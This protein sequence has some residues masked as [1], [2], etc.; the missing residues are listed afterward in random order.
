MRFEDFIKE[1]EGLELFSKGWRGL[2]YRGYWKGKK[3]SIKRAK[4]G[5]EQAIRKECE[6]LRLLK[7]L[8]GFPQ[9]VACGEDFL[10]YE[11]IE[12]VPLEKLNLSR[13]ERIRV[14]LK[15]LEYVKLLDSLGINKDELHRLDK[16]TL[17]TFNGEVYLIDFERGSLGANKR[18]NLSQFLQLLVREGLL[19]KERAVELG[20]S[21]A[22]GLEAYDEVKKIILSAL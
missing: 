19:E 6:I 17:I 8:R 1:V 18:H 16:N 22:R 12:G 13:E 2:I 15:V 7:G 21:Y 4:E 11:Y 3:I 10:A 5:K 20:R 14:Y 9:V